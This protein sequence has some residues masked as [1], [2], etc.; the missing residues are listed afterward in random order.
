MKPPR[1]FSLWK[2]VYFHTTMLKIA[3]R[4]PKKNFSSLKNNQLIGRFGHNSKI[5]Y[6]FQ[7]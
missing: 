1:N 7:H 5:C 6:S 3:F 2:N 4:L